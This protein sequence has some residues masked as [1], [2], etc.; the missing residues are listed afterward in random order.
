MTYVTVVFNFAMT[1]DITRSLHVAVVFN[2][3]MTSYIF[4]KKILGLVAGR[5]CTFAGLSRC[6][7]ATDF[8]KLLDPRFCL[9]SCYIIILGVQI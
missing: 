4:S 5:T 7:V 8:L 3:A 6:V 9:S 1:S 2:F